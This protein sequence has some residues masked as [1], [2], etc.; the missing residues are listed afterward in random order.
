MFPDFFYLNLE[1][2]DSND[3]VEIVFNKIN[4]HDF[5]MFLNFLKFQYKCNITTAI[6]YFYSDYKIIAEYSNDDHK[7]MGNLILK[8]KNIIYEDNNYSFKILTFSQENCISEKCEF[9]NETPLLIRNKYRYTFNFK[10]YKI[11]FTIITNNALT[12]YE[13]KITSNFKHLKKLLDLTEN[14]ILPHIQHSPIIYTVAEKNNFIDIFNSLLSD[15][16]FHNVLYLTN[17]KLNN[18]LDNDLNYVIAPKIKGRSCFCV[19][20]KDQIW[21]V[22]SFHYMLLAKNITL[23]LNSSIYEGYLNIHNDSYIFV[24]TTCIVYKNKNIKDLH[25][26]ERYAFVEELDNLSIEILTIEKLKIKN[27]KIEP[28]TNEKFSYLNKIFNEIKKTISY[29]PDG[30]IIIPINCKYNLNPIYKIKELD[31]I[32]IELEVF[33]NI[34]NE[35][36][37]YCYN[38][39]T[40]DFILFDN[41]FII[42]KNILYN[43]IKSKDI[44]EF[45]IE[46]FDNL[47]ILIPLKIRNDIEYPNE[48]SI[49]ENIWEFICDQN[50]GQ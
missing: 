22:T 28:L 3:N 36:K 10:K 35:L 24:P 1:N 44:V 45:G 4:I 38:S 15:H 13:V 5:Y 30:Y 43:D 34:E 47:I 26:F 14:F 9:N 46:K 32:S 40:D 11:H 50:S 6:D 39:Y 31:K 20:V 12:T 16:T 23:N 7:I 18:L 2:I 29:N 25:F 42:E 33:K 37:L 8:N 19:I 41:N 48:T 21:L 17:K 49:V 27:L